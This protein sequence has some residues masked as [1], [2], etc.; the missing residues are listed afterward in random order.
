LT[1][2]LSALCLAA[3]YDIIDFKSLPETITTNINAFPVTGW[4]PTT[5][6][7]VY[8]NDVNVLLFSAKSR[9][10]FF[11]VVDLEEGLNTITIRIVYTNATEETYSKNIQYDPNYSTEDSELVYAHSRYYDNNSILNS[12]AIVIDTRNNLFLGILKN[13]IVRGITKDGSN[14][15]LSTGERYSTKDHAY[16]G[17][18]LPSYY[19]GLELVFSNDGQYVYNYVNKI[20]LET[21]LIESSIPNLGNDAD[22]TSSDDAIVTVSRYINLTTN[23]YISRNY[24]AGR[25][26]LFAALEIDPADKYVLHTSF[27]YATG[28]LN[29]L[30]I[31]NAQIVKTFGGYSDY[32]GA[33][34]F[35]PDGE[36]GYIGFYGNTY[37]GGGGILILEMSNLTRAG[38]QFLHGARSLTVA[39][40][41]KVYASAFHTFQSSSRG[42][43]GYQD[44][45]GIVELQPINDKTELQIK[46]VF[47]VN[48]LSTR[49]NPYYG[50]NY[51]FHKL[52][53]YEYSC[54]E[55]IECGEAHWSGSSFCLGGDVYEN[56]IT[57]TCMNPGTYES[58]CTNGTE[59]NLKYTCEFGCTDGS[60]NPKPISTGNI[61]VIGRKLYV[62]GT[63]YTAKGI[64]YAPVPIGSSPDSGYDIT[65][66]SELRAR[67]FP[68]LREMNC[69][70]IRTWGK[71]GQ[72]SFLDDSWNNGVN[73]IRVLMG[74]WLGTNRDY[75][76]QTV[77]QSILNEFETYVTAY[78]DHPAV[79]VWAIGNEENYFYGGGNPVK[80]A[81]YFSL[82]NEMA[83]LAYTIEGA[84]YHPVLAISLEMPGAFATVGNEGAG[85]DD[86][87]IPYVDIWG[88]NNYPGHTFGNWFDTYKT[89]TSKPLI[90]TE[91]GI[92]ALNNTDKTEQ[93]A[94]QA[95]WILANWNE[96]EANCVGGSLM[97]Y[98]DEW[99]KAGSV[100]SH[101]YGG[102]TTSTH[103]DG[104]SNEEWWG[105]MRT[106]DNGASPDIMQPREVYYALKNAW[107]ENISL[108]IPLNQGWNLISIPLIMEDDSVA[109]VFAGLSYSRLFYY[110]D[111][112]KVPTIVNNTL[113]YWIKMNNAD[114]FTVEGLL[115]D[116]IINYNH[117]W[118]LV[119]YPYLEEKPISELFTNATVYTYNN[120][121][122]YSYNPDKPTNTLTKF[123]PGFGYWIKND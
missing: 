24:V 39:N 40:N 8:V 81:A 41:S 49:A 26:S 20:N 25:R 30:N 116:G 96:I 92:D 79:L 74:F 119:G 61:K 57:P 84:D 56:Y 47:F 13:K 44:Q 80:H 48:L 114:T 36:K 42:W 115:S 33:I 12:G 107:R 22:I 31:S 91:Y 101:D 54:Y 59:S 64:G 60:C 85:S 5:T 69:N 21:N 82:I 87:S 55:D 19:D 35:S 71:V 76:S 34:D 63:E 117:G 6:A 105:I 45:R 65:V 102:Y 23:T 123:T 83:K 7:N 111:G 9:Y 94:T 77:R 103:P 15:I 17:R 78:K 38:Y 67:D 4:V 52:G 3:D 89:K 106:V 27:S 11:S 90:I 43:R 46:K 120:S 109:S 110:D 75:T 73:P 118:N 58:Y 99:W 95:D 93:E 50:D 121:N 70:T 53:T 2:L 1:V 68:L 28:E 112:W 97:A 14:I 29:I 98:S 62:D 18:T 51:I 32:A 37:Y 66:H 10:D 122:W 113:G 16:T 100:N 88:I 108:I 72:E 104:Y 86:A